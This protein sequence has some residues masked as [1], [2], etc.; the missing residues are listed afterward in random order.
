M[1]NDFV[2]TVTPWLTLAML[3]FGIWQTWL[4]SKVN[5]LKADLEHFKLQYQIVV[6]DRDEKAK[7]LDKCKDRCLELQSALLL[8]ERAAACLDNRLSAHT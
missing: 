4:N 1:P 7:E 5:A 6:A 8:H 3:V 2:S